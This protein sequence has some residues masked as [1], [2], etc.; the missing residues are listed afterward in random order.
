VNDEYIWWKALREFNTEFRYRNA[1]TDDFRA[2]LERLHKRSWKRFFQDWVYGSGYPKLSGEVKIVGKKIRVKIENASSSDTRFEVP[3]DL[4]WREGEDWRHTRLML[5]PGKNR[6]VIECL[7]APEELS[8]VDLDRVL[9]KHD[10]RA[11]Q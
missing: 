10:V 11:V 4:S 9:G 8:I 6:Q 1:G 7:V 2:V 5:S 3:I